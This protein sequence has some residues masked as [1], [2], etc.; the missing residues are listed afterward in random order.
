MAMTKT[1]L[2]ML[3]AIFFNIVEAAP[4]LLATLAQQLEL[5]TCTWACILSK[6]KTVNI[7]SD[8][9]YSFGVV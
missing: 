5:Y 7:Y 9:R 4:L 3:F 6:G 8:N 2:G 1:V